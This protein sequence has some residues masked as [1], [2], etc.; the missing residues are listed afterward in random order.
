M[1]FRGDTRRQMGLFDGVIS[2]NPGELLRVGPSPGRTFSGSLIFQRHKAKS[3]G[4]NRNPRNS[5][6]GWQRRDS[7]DDREFAGRVP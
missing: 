6:S 5:L 2:Q 7:S 3:T 4:T 1:K